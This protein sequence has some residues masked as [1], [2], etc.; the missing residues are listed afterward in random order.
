MLSLQTGIRKDMIY[1]LS[2]L[3]AIDYQPTEK[4]ILKGGIGTN[5][6][7]ASL[8]IGVITKKIELNF[9]TQLHQILGWSPDFSITYDF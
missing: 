2:F 6:T 3:T 5:P 7:I 1:P 4:I 9:A 8:G